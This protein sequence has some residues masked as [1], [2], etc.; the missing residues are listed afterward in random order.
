MKPRIRP[1]VHSAWVG[2]PPECFE[3]LDG[4]ED[5]RGDELYQRF[6]EDGF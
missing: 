6:K 2:P 1:V 5:V 3:E 4:I